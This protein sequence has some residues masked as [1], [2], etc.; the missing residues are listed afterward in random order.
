VLSSGHDFLGRSAGS[1][2]LHISLA[3]M[4]KF[5]INDNDEDSVTG[6]SATIQTGSDWTKIYGLVYVML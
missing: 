4:Q 2:S 1:G 5:E 3:N 6:V